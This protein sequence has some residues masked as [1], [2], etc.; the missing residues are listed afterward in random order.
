MMNTDGALRLFV[1][2]GRIHVAYV[3]RKGLWGMQQYMTRRS[4]ALAQMEK[5]SIMVLF[6]GEGIPESMDACCPFEANHP[7]FYLTGLRRENMALVLSRSAS[8]DKTILFIEE[9]VPSMERWTGKRVTKD[10]ARTISGVEDV[11][12]IDSLSS[13]LGRMMAREQVAAAYFDCY[14]N[15]MTDVDSYNMIKAKAFAAA[16]PAVTLKN[17]H[18]MLAAMRMVKDD[19]EIACIREAIGVTDKGL[20][21]IL[22][23]LA[24][25]QMEYQAQAEFEY[26]IRW[27]GAE[28]TSFATIAGS[29]LNGCMLHYETNHCRMEDGTLLLLDLGA[30]VKGY[31]ADITRTYPVNGKYSP[32]QKEIYDIVLR[33]NQEVTRAA[34]PGLT[35]KALNEICKQVLADGLMR[36]GK[37]ESADQI[38]T[39]YMHGVSHHLGLDTHDAIAHDEVVLAPGMV[40]TNE[41]GLYIDEEEIGIRIE[42]DLLITQDG[43]EVLSREIPRTT[44]EIEALMAR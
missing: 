6:S 11:R 39:Y 42:D 2:C 37:I 29:G 4:K 16:Y 33:A 8:E 31:C 25:G 19:A 7:F 27:H 43:C 30:K 1:I 9:A 21:R 14:R 32:R 34:R 36:I 12:Y 13:A 24:P 3:E 41:P 44:E 17:A 38:G 35:L 18:P 23:K 5:G 28:G 10:E 40:I 15:A 22:Q 26:A 20:R